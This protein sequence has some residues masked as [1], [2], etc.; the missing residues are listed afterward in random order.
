MNLVWIGP[1]VA[2]GVFLIIVAYFVIRMLSL[3]SA[4]WRGPLNRRLT[5]YLGNPAAPNNREK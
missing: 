4:I 5:E 2:V 3:R 1:S